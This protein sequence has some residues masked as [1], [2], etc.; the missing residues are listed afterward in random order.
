MDGSMAN[1]R[2][3][4]GPAG[5]GGAAAAPPWSCGACTFSNPPSRVTC[6]MCRGPAPRGAG[7]PR[8][9]FDLLLASAMR[10]STPPPLAVSTSK[11]KKKRAKTSADAPAQAPAVVR[12]GGQAGPAVVSR[13]T[14]DAARA[15]TSLNAPQRSRA[16]QTPP[17]PPPPPPPPPHRTHPQRSSQ[18]T[19]Q[20]PPPPQ[21]S[22]QK[23]TSGAGV[24]VDAPQQ[25]PRNR[26]A[27]PKNPTPK[28]KGGDA[29]TRADV[30]ADV[31]PPPPPS[32]SHPPPPLPVSSN[33]GG[34]VPKQ[35]LQLHKRRS[36]RFVPPISAGSAVTPGKQREVKRRRPSDSAQTTTTTTSSAAVGSGSSSSGKSGSSARDDVSDSSAPPGPPPAPLDVKSRAFLAL[37]K[38]F[39]FDSF[40]SELQRD[41]VIA[42]LERRD[43]VAIMPTGGGK[44][45]IF[46]LPALMTPGVR[47]LARSHLRMD[48]IPQ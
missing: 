34:A 41:A 38:H 11:G 40:K 13:A 44:S 30:N 35:P 3:A 16:A 33:T 47:L 7:A 32:H 9:A 8:T 45:L 28:R 46:Q 14:S 19:T 25:S 31:P 24:R 2:T 27:S 39:G 20:S 1:A 23:R 26:G 4:A 17:S 18:R 6:E 42:V 36:G 43:V 5:G 37:R 29:I 15:N 48:L 12:D 21:R 22:S 10:S